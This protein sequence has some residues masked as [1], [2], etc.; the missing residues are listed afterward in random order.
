MDNL[1]FKNKK[2]ASAKSANNKEGNTKQK[3][4]IPRRHII[5]P[6]RAVREAGGAIFG[7]AFTNQF[8]PLREPIRR[9]GGNVTQHI[10]YLHFQHNPTT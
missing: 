4:N 5:E 10:Q 2:E 1:L 9:P 7:A 6:R 8:H 3:W